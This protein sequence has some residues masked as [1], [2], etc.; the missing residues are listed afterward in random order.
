MPKKGPDKKKLEKIMKIVN[1]VR[2]KG[3]WVREL[4]RQTNLP[5][6]TVHLYINKFLKN[7][8]KVETIKIGEFTHSQMKIVKLRC[9]K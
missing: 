8:V 1:S 2:S 9:N 5:V 7:Q 6:S 3:I 4:A